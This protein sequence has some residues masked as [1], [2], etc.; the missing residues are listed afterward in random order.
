MKF[1]RVSIENFGRVQHAE[2]GLA[3]RG[4]ILIQ[5]VNEDGSSANSNGA[6]KSTVVEAISWALYGRTAKGVTGD[7]VI[8]RAA[9]KGCRVEV[10]VEDGGTV[11][12]IARHRKHKT[13]KNKLE[14]WSHEDDVERARTLTKGTDKLT[15]AVVDQIIGCPHEVFSAAVYAGQESVPDLPGMTD[16]QLKL[17]IEEAA[18]ITELDAAHERARSRARAAGETL[19][20]IE[21]RKEHAETNVT[22]ARERLED[23]QKNVK[24]WEGEREARV[25]DLEAHARVL[26][27]E[28]KSAKTG[29][30]KHKPMNEINEALEKAVESKRRLDDEAAKLDELQT[31]FDRSDRTVTQ[32]EARLE[33]AKENLRKAKT[34]LEH[35]RGRVGE[36]CETC[37]RA[38]D[39]DTLDVAISVAKQELREAREWAVELRDNLGKAQSARESAR[40]RLEAYRGSMTDPAHLEAHMGDLRAQKNERRRQEEKITDAH[41]RAR[42]AIEAVKCERERD[43]PHIG[44]VADR[45]ND[46]EAAREASKGLADKHAA[47]H[48]AVRIAKG[49]VEVFSPKGVR[50]RVLDTVTPYLNARTA[51][52]LGALSDGQFEASWSTVTMTAK[53][54]PREKFAIEVRDI[55]DGGNFT[56]LSGGEKRRVRLACALALQDLVATRAA[57][58]I[59][60]FV[61]DE[62]DAALD[63]AGLERLM[64]VL[65]EKGRERGTVIIISHSD[66][67][68]WCSNT[69]T[70]RRKGGV[71]EVIE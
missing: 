48:R 63:T 29:L 23:A 27:E 49:T 40:E 12:G 67:R 25:M 26:L 68:D 17:L 64:T 1:R 54:E 41:R 62:I 53:G 42:E 52:Y 32:L 69:I 3:D 19:M 10:V 38:H 2:I 43:N 50:A 6:G 71:S 5:G 34:H 35:T 13:G 18:G 39:E 24:R 11:Y 8:N 36:P 59:D 4:L 51:F 57:K 58:P 14:V 28:A 37:G 44:E 60:L 20:E 16:K 22:H 15:Q 33:G 66:M 61:A 31:A 30:D 47:A 55:I 9:G 21:N 56:D 7:S 70:V 65:E 46:L 45:Q